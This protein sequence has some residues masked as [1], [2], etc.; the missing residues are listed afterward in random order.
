M[1][2]ERA[3][4]RALVHYLKTTPSCSKIKVCAP[5]NEN[6]K[7][8]LDMGVDVGCTD[9]ILG[10]RVGSLYHILYLEI[11]TKNGELSPSQIGWNAE[12]DEI[13]ASEN[14]CRQVAYGYHEGIRIIEAWKPSLNF[15][16]L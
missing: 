5:M 6:S 2:V 7:H 1:K 11:K 3:I 12:F 9:L 14:C 4:Q 15:L 16:P 10:T 13:Y 8:C